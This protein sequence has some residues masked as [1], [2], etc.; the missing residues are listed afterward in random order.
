M[1]FAGAACVGAWGHGFEPGVGTRTLG[2]RRGIWGG[3]WGW[4]VG[5]GAWGRGPGG[6]PAAGGVG[7]PRPSAPGLAAHPTPAPPAGVPPAHLLV[8]GPG[9]DPRR[10]EWSRGSS[11]GLRGCGG[12]AGGEPSSSASPARRARRPRRPSTRGRSEP[13]QGGAADE[14]RAGARG[15]RRARARAA[16]AAAEAGGES[17]EVGSPTRAARGRASEPFGVRERS[18]ACGAQRA[19]AVRA[20]RARADTRRFGVARGSRTGSPN[21][22]GT[23]TEAHGDGALWGP[24][25][26]DAPGPP[27]PW[28]RHLGA[29]TLPR[30]PCART[31]GGPCPIPTHWHPPPRRSPPPPHCRPPPVSS[32]SRPRPSGAR[33]R[34]GGPCP[35]HPRG[36][37]SSE[38]RLLRCPGRSSSPRARPRPRGAGEFVPDAARVCADC[39][40]LSA[41]PSHAHFTRSP[42]PPPV[43]GHRGARRR[44]SRRTVPAPGHPPSQPHSGA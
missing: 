17:A 1:P 4:D 19:R 20:A 24:P 11:A 27:Y 30:P 29:S 10:R 8:L 41:N 26:R 39:P 40:S 35:A 3:S 9:P 43:V 13:G 32:L 22:P 6:K 28:P 44:S 2:P 21:F 37:R 34:Q 31:S 23:T 5:L 18:G 7:P 38:G 42:T 14:V 36:A 33:P 16:A 15:E 25:G 12:G